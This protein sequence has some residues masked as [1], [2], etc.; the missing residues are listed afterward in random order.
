M[1]QMGQKLAPALWVGINFIKALNIFWNINI[2]PINH[3]EGHIISS[4]IYPKDSN[5]KIS[6]GDFIIK[7]LILLP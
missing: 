5:N 2:Y 7:I 6:K 3:M 4:L 1:N